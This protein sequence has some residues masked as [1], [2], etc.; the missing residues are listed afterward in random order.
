M[1]ALSRSRTLAALACT[2]ASAAILAH[3]G[4]PSMDMHGVSSAAETCVAVAAHAVDAPAA[5]GWLPVVALGGAA[6]LA[7]SIARVLLYRRQTVRARA[8]PDELLVP[9]RC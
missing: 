5:S 9:L 6:L 4:V 7:P 8:G 1:A 2:V 3:H